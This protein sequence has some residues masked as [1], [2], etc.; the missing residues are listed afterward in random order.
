MSLFGREFCDIVDVV[1]IT[2]GFLP[3]GSSTSWPSSAGIWSRS[4]A[5]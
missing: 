2:S 3:G 1:V 5:C 4:Q